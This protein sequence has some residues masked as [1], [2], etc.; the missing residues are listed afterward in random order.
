VRSLRELT[1]VGSP[2]IVLER[3]AGITWRRP[4]L[5][6]AVVGTLTL[7]AVGFGHDVA[8]RLH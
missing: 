8:G 5:V 1:L 7:L 3:I 6:L 2:A 4:R